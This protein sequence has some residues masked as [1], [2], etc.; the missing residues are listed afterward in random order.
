MS[1]LSLT[2]LFITEGETRAVSGNT[3]FLLDDP[4]AVWLV[5]TGLVEVFSVA[6][7]EG[8]S[9]GSR[10][11]F[12]SVPA[13]GLLFGVD[14]S[15][16]GLGRGFLGVG[17]VNTQLCRLPLARFR[18]LT[19]IAAM[20]E[21]IVPLVDQWVV[22]LSIG[23]AKDINPR[24]DF[25]LESG[26]K[27]ELE[28]SQ[29]IRAKE[30][31]VWVRQ[32]RGQMLFIG[33]EEVGLAGKEAYFPLTSDS[34]LEALGAASVSVFATAQVLLEEPAA[35]WGGLD[36]LYQSILSCEFLN[37]PLAEADEFN[38]IRDRVTWDA[39]ARS[40]ATAALGSVLSVE[41]AAATD[42]STDSL[43]F[44]ACRRVAV[45]QGINLKLPP[46]LARKK[47][48]KDPLN[49]I[50]RASRMRSREVALRGHWWRES[51]GPLVAFLENGHSPAAL[52]P[53]K[54]GYVLFNPADGTTS[55][56]TPESAGALEPMAWMFYRPFPQRAL[57]SHELIF[58]GGQGSGHEVRMMGLIA[59]IVGLL[60]LVTPWATGVIFDTIIPEAQHGPLMQLIMGLLLVALGTGS[61]QFCRN[62]IVLRMEGKMDG[63]L[64]AAIF[65]RLLD[66]PVDFFKD[67]SSGD[68][69]D[70]A[71]AITSI[72]Q[73]LS[74]GM[75]TSL[76]GALFSLLSL[77]LLL[78][79]HMKL[80]I[81]AICLALIASIFTFSLSYAKVN[82]Q[83]KIVALQ[84]RTSGLV[85]QLLTG[86]SK[87]RN[88]GA[89]VHA[90][91]LWAD[92][93]SEQKRYA[94]RARR[95]ENVVTTF[96]TVYPLLCSAVIFFMLFYFIRGGGEVLATGKFLAFFAAFGTFMGGVLGISDAA[97]QL[98]NVGPLLER[99]K[100]ILSTL[101]EA[102]DG[103]LEAPDL[104]GKIEIT[105]ASY[106]YFEKDPLVLKNISISIRAG[107]FVAFVGPSGSGKSTVLRLL[108]G[109]GKPESGAI[110]YD[111]NDLA[112]LDITS[113]RRQ[114]G[115]V[116]QNGKLLP[117]DIFTNIVGALPLTEQDAMD[118]AA[119]AG[120][121]EDI[122]KMP[123]GL[124]T[125]IN[126]GG[127]TL[128]GGQQ[129]RLMIARAIASRP[130]ILFFDEATSALDNRT[131]AVVSESLE[132]LQATRVVIA[133]RLS[134]II[135]ADR[136]VVISGGELVQEGNYETLVNQPGIF[137]DLARRQLVDAPS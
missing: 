33:M 131:Q 117:G 90:F 99:I 48:I 43:L 61:F 52:L 5:Q 25:T 46:E 30:G 65:D 135:N 83:R 76:L 121:A 134:T 58:F 137:A 82:I 19:K 127:G 92:R 40:R 36:A 136:I 123:M 126:A 12:F 80:A 70:R 17:L 47:A 108:L 115:V 86:I 29:S 133:H 27:L 105:E 10:Y 113:V 88:A 125:V 60:G 87:L 124:H 15:V 71:M 96:T 89:E 34:R 14:S 114:I 23:V 18:E 63:R 79:Y 68:L 98:F 81:V 102:T 6:V 51:N 69:A 26:Q 59:L 49:A 22:A 64:Q 109:F 119:M 66:L 122:E 106:R 95:Y 55:E 112:N 38:R 4:G 101:P 11:H 7:V 128:S 129:Q 39:K 132:R 42:E 78:Y 73:V 110:H 8:R 16:G 91:A 118:A 67:Y 84:G 50:V 28:R 107:E 37:R 1:T 54:G 3:P 35:L 77:A 62:L 13:G 41:G 97:V 57:K 53:S 74:N 9:S 104:T 45:F 100:P 31:V 93:F 75:L 111:G 120:L 2:E 24:T 44:Q 94:F 72:R 21:L 56:V 103:K 20:R 116:L 85:L 32:E 130:R